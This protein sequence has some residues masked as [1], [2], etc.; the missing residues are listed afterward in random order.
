[1]VRNKTQKS[2]D[3]EPKKP[4]GRKKQSRQV[5]KPESH[6]PMDT[7]QKDMFTS[8][9]PMIMMVMMMAITMP[10]MKC[11]SQNDRESTDLKTDHE[12]VK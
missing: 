7:P 4:R 12:D 8:M 1:M 10:M 9:M 6:Q 5:V 11:L 2:N 3:I